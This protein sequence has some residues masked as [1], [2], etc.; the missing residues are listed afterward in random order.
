MRRQQRECPPEVK[1]SITA[2]CYSGREGVSAVARRHGLYP[3]Q[4]F[5]RRR[6]LRKQ[7]EVAGVVLSAREPEVPT[8]VPARVEVDVTEASSP[9]RRP[10]RRRRS[11]GAAVELKIDGYPI[12]R[13]SRV[14][15][16]AAGA[17]RSPCGGPRAGPRDRR[18]EGYHG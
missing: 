16:L 7:L 18:A 9:R 13:A 17:W 6:G 14:T 10:H 4:V 3:S 2:E 8:F 12:W 11:T 15:G 1:A 5:I